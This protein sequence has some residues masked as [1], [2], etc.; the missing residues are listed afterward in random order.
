MKFLYGI[1]LFFLMF[2]PNFP[3]I[4]KFSSNFFLIST[5]LSYRKSYSYHLVLSLLIMPIYQDYHGDS[6]DSCISTWDQI[7]VS[8]K[9]LL[10]TYE[11]VL[12]DSPVVSSFLSTQ[13][14]CADFTQ[15]CAGIIATMNEFE[16]ENSDPTIH[17]HI[18]PY[19]DSAN[20]KSEYYIQEEATIQRALEI[21]DP[22]TIHQ[23]NPEITEISLNLETA[24]S[25]LTQQ[26]AE[27]QNLQ[28]HITKSEYRNSEIQT[29]TTATQTEA[30]D[31]SGFPEITK[32]SDAEVTIVPYG[33]TNGWIEGDLV[34]ARAVMV[35][36]PPPKLPHLQ[37][38]AEAFVGAEDAVAR[39]RNSG[40][41]DK[42]AVALTNGGGDD[43]DLDDE[44]SCSAEVGASIRGKCTSSSAAGRTMAATVE[45]DAMR[46]K[47]QRPIALDPWAVVES[48]EPQAAPDGAIV[49]T[50]RRTS[51]VVEDGEAM[52]KKNDPATMTGGPRARKLRRFFL[53]TPP[54]LLVALFP[55]NRGGTVVAD[56]EEEWKKQDE[57]IVKIA[58]CAIDGAGVGGATVADS[59]ICINAM[60]EK[61]RMGIDPLFSFSVNVGNEGNALPPLHW[62]GFKVHQTQFESPLRWIAIG[63]HSTK[64]YMGLLMGKVIF[65]QWNPGDIF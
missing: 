42:E 4:L 28:F 34:V 35:T 45:D 41:Q 57:V 23:S 8:L 22:S 48:R 38:H 26:Q 5:I 19:Q 3:L 17:V 52:E 9:C 51:A 63:P 64:C 25:V 7:Q 11:A 60:N 20:Q 29:S 59:S 53:L 21:T 49:E 44:A 65:K 1:I 40:T 12:C 33:G 47:S 18:Q 55:W 61:E 13:Q 14:I 43:I 15:T 2:F 32:Q 50:G 30:S 24:V 37:L 62:L 10:P 16:A 27:I 58:G 46:W 36:R 6:K 54:P 39:N 56:G 31:C